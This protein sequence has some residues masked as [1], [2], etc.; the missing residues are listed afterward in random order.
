ME[1]LKEAAALRTQCSVPYPFLQLD[2][3]VKSVCDVLELSVDV[4]K[5]AFFGKRIGCLSDSMRSC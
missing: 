1:L 3:L 2:S 4:E 5:L